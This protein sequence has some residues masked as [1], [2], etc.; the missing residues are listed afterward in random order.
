MGYFVDG[1]LHEVG[2][3]IVHVSQTLQHCRN[4]AV[5]HVDALVEAVA[6]F[7]K[8][9]VEE[10]VRVEL[11]QLGYCGWYLLLPSVAQLLV[12]P[13][14]L[15]DLAQ[16]LYQSSQQGVV[17]ALPALGLEKL[18]D[19]RNGFGMVEPQR[20][21]FPRSLPIEPGGELVV[22]V[23][24]EHEGFELLEAIGV[25]CR[26]LQLLLGHNLVER[27]HS[28]LAPVSELSQLGASRCR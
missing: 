26:V 14:A 9:L 21:Q 24:P 28:V 15:H 6:N 19:A 4:V 5:R 1:Q 23:D 8:H 18:E 7:I 17:E 25:L 10:S 3:N 13:Q 22:Q 20:S 11:S 12:L 27:R 2:V 16:P